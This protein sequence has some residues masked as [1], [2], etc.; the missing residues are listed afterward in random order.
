MN[1]QEFVTSD[2]H[3][4]FTTPLGSTESVFLKI[5][6]RN[7]VTNSCM[8]GITFLKNKGL[9]QKS[10]ALGLWGKQKSTRRCFQFA[11]IQNIKFC[12]RCPVSIHEYFWKFVASQN[13]FWKHPSC[14]NHSGKVMCINFDAASHRRSGFLFTRKGFSYNSESLRF[15]VASWKIRSKFVANS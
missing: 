11:S 7:F 9:F 15:F 10:I 12:R 8:F 5:L 1:K 14:R 6:L 3:S 4:N 13:A 2:S